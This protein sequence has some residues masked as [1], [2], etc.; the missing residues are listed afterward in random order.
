[1][2]KYIVLTAFIL[3][4]Y[5]VMYAPFQL[6]IPTFEAMS[7]DGDVVTEAVFEESSIL[8]FFRSTCGY[9]VYEMQQWK[10]FKQ[11]H[12]QTK[13]IAVLHKESLMQAGYFFKGVIYPFDLVIN[14]PQD[15]LWTHLGASF[16]PQSYL[17]GKG[18]KVI[19]S[20]GVMKPEDY[21]VLSSELGPI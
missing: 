17:I 18:R 1:M 9:C 15:A 16:T 14:D 5:M 4:G 20:Y 10:R 21:L 19:S 12:P 7:I 11:Q 3:V 2:F 13:I 8:H 6:T